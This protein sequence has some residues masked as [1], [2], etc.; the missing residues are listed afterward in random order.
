M[1]KLTQAAVAGIDVAKADLEVALDGSGERLKLGNDAAGFKTLIGWL[2]RHGVTIAGLE[3]SGG[4]E[5]GVARAMAEA[6]L[7]VRNVNPHKLRHYA[8]ALGRLAKT[9]AIDAAIIARYTA[10]LPTRPARTD[11]LQVA[12]AELV[13]AR[14]Q[15]SDDKVSLANQIEHLKEPMLRRL[16]TSRLKR[17]E[18]DLLLVSKRI[19]ELIAADPALCASDQLIQSLPGAGPVLSHTLI[20]HCPEIQTANRRELAALAGLA[21][22]DHQ[23]GALKGRRSIWGGRAELRRVLYMAALSASRCNPV[24]S[25][26]HHRLVT[27]GKPPKLAIVAVARKLLTILG[28]ILRAAKP[29][30]PQP[31]P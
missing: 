14:R 26:F 18:A 17:L 5:R 10:T 21:P 11:K 3:P 25:A 16:F 2:R 30:S 12:L 6:G 27:A 1:K 13:A 22:Y 31:Q 20:A 8:R 24:L 19:A 7:S 28:A 4:Y 23:S 15:L 9:D 29:W